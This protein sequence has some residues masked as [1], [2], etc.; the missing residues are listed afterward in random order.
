MA[1]GMTELILRMDQIA[2]TPAALSACQALF[3]E[4][5]GKRDMQ[6]SRNR[7]VAQYQRRKSA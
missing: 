3:L 5:E 7:R 2:G 1:G 6:V 4:R